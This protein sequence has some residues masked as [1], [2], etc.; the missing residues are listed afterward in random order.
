LLSYNTARATPVKTAGPDATLVVRSPGAGTVVVQGAELSWEMQSSQE[1]PDLVRSGRGVVGPDGTLVL[2]PYGTCKVAG[3]SLEQARTEIEKQLSASVKN[4]SVRLSAMLPAPPLRELAWRPAARSVVSGSPV[5]T[6][7][8]RDNTAP[9]SWNKEGP[10]LPVGKETKEGKDTGPLLPPSKDKDDGMV[11]LPA[12][13]PLPGAAPLATVPHMHP[14]L[15]P[16]PL[17]HLPL[18]PPPSELN[19]VVLP[20]YVIGVTDVLQIDSLRGLETQPVRGPHLVRPDGTV[21]VGVYGPV[22]VAGST[23]EQAREALARKIFARLDQAPPPAPEGKKQPPRPT[24]QDVFDNLSVDVLAYNSKT[25]YVVFDGGGY[26]EQVYSFPVTGNETVLDAIG[27]L[28]GLPWNASKYHIWLA[29]RTP[30]SGASQKKLPVD[31]LGITQ[32]GGTATNYQIMP[33]DRVFVQADRWRT[34]D[35]VIAKI[36]SPIERLFGVTLLGSQTVNSIRSGT[37]GGGR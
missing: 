37:V 5:A 20:P 1:R 3:L 24:Y 22:M 27:K 11:E 28:N 12:P 15:G 29:R 10:L 21:N 31:W 7:M 30:G 2:G 36:L 19:R 33:G 8:R 32:N 26:G 23:L 9:V 17:G 6:A 35:A 18:P 4:P 13:Q 16:G 34:A 14:P 25:Y